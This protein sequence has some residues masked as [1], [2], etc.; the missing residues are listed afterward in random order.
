MKIQV[1]TGG[2]IEGRKV[3]QGSG[4]GGEGLMERAL[5]FGLGAD[6]GVGS[7]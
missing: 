5:G 6:S 3:R 4:G 2:E 1:G 7:C